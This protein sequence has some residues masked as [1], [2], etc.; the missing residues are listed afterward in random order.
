MSEKSPEESTSSEWCM[1]FRFACSKICQKMLEQ[2][3]NPI[4]S[5]TMPAAEVMRIAGEEVF[6][7]LLRLHTRKVRRLR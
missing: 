1:G 5:D 6:A 7:M 4:H 2:S 3:K